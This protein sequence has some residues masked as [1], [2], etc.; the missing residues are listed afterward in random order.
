MAQYLPMLLVSVSTISTPAPDDSSLDTQAVGQV[1]YLSH[2]WQEEDVARSWRNMTR[3]KDSIQNGAR[4]E[5][6]SWRTWWK[7]RNKLPTVSPETLNWL[8]DSDVTWLYGPLH[9]AND[10]AP[11]PRQSTST[12]QS[13]TDPKRRSPASSRPNSPWELKPILKHRSISEL[14]SISFPPT[15][16]SDTLELP[17]EGYFS[18]RGTPLSQRTQSLDS[19]DP[20]RSRPRLA[21][22]KSD[23][24]ISRRNPFRG[25]SPPLPL[26]PE[27]HTVVGP[28]KRTN[29]QLA[30]SSST[31]ESQ[32][33][34]ESS[35]QQRRHI[36]F[37]TFVEQCIAIEQPK[38]SDDEEEEGDEYGY[39]DEGYRE[40]DEDSNEEYDSEEDVLEMRSSRRGS[41]RS[42]ASPL[43]GL[44]SIHTAEREHVTIAPIAPTILKTSASPSPATS[45]Y[46]S[47]PYGGALWNEDDEELF[48]VGTLRGSGTHSPEADI[49][50]SAVP[51]VFA[52]PQGS[53]YAD[54][55]GV[56]GARA[57]GGYPHH[58]EGRRS[59]SSSS[60]PGG[61]YE[62]G[63]VYN[64]SGTGSGR[65]DVN[66]V[67][68][69]HDE[70]EGYGVSN[71]VVY[72]PYRGPK[73]RVADE[74][75]S[76]TS[77]QQ[78]E[79]RSTDSKGGSSEEGTVVPA[80]AGS[81]SS[82]GSIASDPSISPPTAHLDTAATSAPIPVPKA[83]S[84]ARHVHQSPSPVPSATSISTS[85]TTSNGSNHSPLLD[86]DS[87][88]RSTSPITSVSPGGDSS[89]GRSARRNSSDRLRIEKDERDRPRG[90]SRSRSIGG[91]DGSVSP[92]STLSRRDSVEG[93]VGLG[94]GSSAYSCGPRERGQRDVSSSLSPEDGGRTGRIG[95]VAVG[96]N[97]GL[98]GR[99]MG[100]GSDGG[101][102]LSPPSREVPP[103]T[104]Y[105]ARGSNTIPIDIVP[106]PA[107]PTQPST[108]VPPVVSTPSG[109]RAVAVDVLPVAARAVANTA[110]VPTISPS[111]ESTPTSSGTPT[112]T[113]ASGTTT[114]TRTSAPSSVASAPAII[115]IPPSPSI[116]KAALNS[117]TPT[118][119]PIPIAASRVEE[120]S[121]VGRA[122]SSAKGYLG[123]IWGSPAQTAAR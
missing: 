93:S 24:N 69:E 90:R 109:P 62:D 112:P 121:L 77:S 87:R 18:D 119:P 23:T 61:S 50:E 6:A 115:S 10:W 116:S 52:P 20:N 89:R 118:A 108:R 8:K 106:V 39:E 60:S 11:P 7:Q 54:R 68:V 82:T 107:P 9:T 4:L 72:E 59:R 17:T 66:D 13:I 26:I 28:S 83:N 97:I 5:N 1:D 40:D 44:E 75:S 19:Q 34:G 25:D 98:N 99:R 88:G 100:S 29:S 111:K 74:A 41:M 91:A 71:E 49:Q 14:L 114:P 38:G 58:K 94:Y 96:R 42:D 105:T 3:R 36:S 73:S 22:T 117:T 86:I 76:T 65:S 45:L 64:S 47:N 67:E 63:D 32:D 53:V 120:A 51:L 43:T 15:P 48:R 92:R 70:G 123:A 37:N 30:T 79:V 95:R 56:S 12:A 85:T 46:P 84:P 21:H 2:D 122:M 113:S 101:S 57:F 35:T 81:A 55:L 80:G 104:Q 103:Q 102:S 16:N 78:M 27:E 110:V 31:P 33:S